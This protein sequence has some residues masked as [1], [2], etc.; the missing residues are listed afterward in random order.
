MHLFSRESLEPVISKLWLRNALL[1]IPLIA[2]SKLLPH[3]VNRMVHKL[4]KVSFPRGKVEFT[5]NMKTAIYI[6]ESGKLQ[7]AV[8]DGEGVVNTF[9]KVLSNK[10]MKY[11]FG[12][13]FLC[14]NLTHSFL[15][16]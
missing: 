1:T 10:A 12:S 11:L 7:M 4:E 3:E 8:T 14:S 9:D 6:L 16:P 5:G 15:I 2:K 13:L